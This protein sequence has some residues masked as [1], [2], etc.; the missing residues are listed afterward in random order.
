MRRDGLTV[1]GGLNTGDPGGPPVDPDSALNMVVSTLGGTLIM[2]AYARSWFDADGGMRLPS[3]P[4]LDPAD[5]E[6]GSKDEVL[7][8]RWMRWNFMEETAR[9]LY[10]SI[11]LGAPQIEGLEFPANITRVFHGPCVEDEYDFIANQRFRSAKRARCRS[12]V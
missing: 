1:P 6:E 5:A 7:G 3:L 12:C 4:T 8:S 2:E 11:D 10:G 9:F